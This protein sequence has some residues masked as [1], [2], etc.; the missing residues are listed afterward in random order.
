MNLCGVR[1]IPDVKEQLVN[2]ENIMWVL[3]WLQLMTTDGGIKY[4]HLG[5]YKNKDVCIK[6]LDKAQV[7]ITGSNEAMACLDLSRSN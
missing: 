6:E 1:K 3:V 5:T 2:V 7:M 4:Y